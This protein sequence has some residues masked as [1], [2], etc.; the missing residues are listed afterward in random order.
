VEAALA[1]RPDL[2]LMDVGLKGDVDG[3]RASELINEKMH[4]PVVYLTGDS[5][6]KTLQRAKAASAYGY[7]LKPFHIRNL[8]VAIEVAVD[9]FEMERRLEDSQ[10]TYATILGSIADGVVAVDTQGCVRFMNG[11]AERLTGWAT[12][13]AQG[14]QWRTVLNILDNS[15]V[16]AEVDLVAQVLTSR[17]TFS[18]GPGSVVVG[19]DGTRAPVDGHLAC[20]VDSLGRVVGASIALHDVTNARKAEADLRASA[21]QLRAVIDTAVDG[22]L[23]LDAVGTIL[24]LNPACE[25]LFRYTSSEMTGLNIDAVM[26][27][28]L[29]GAHSNPWQFDLPESRRPMLVSARAVICRR[30]DRSTFP[31]EISVGE[32][33]YPGE[34]LFVCTVHDVSEQR[35]LEAALLDAVGREQR[36][37]ATDLHDGLGQ[38]LT[39]L[40]LLLSALTNTA[41]A[42]HNPHVQDLERA[43]EVVRHA[44]HSSQTIARG[45]SPIGPTDGG[46]IRALRDLV[47][48]LTDPSGPNV[49]ISVSEVAR[50]GL[51]AAASDHL[52]RIAQEALTNALK[53]AHAHSIRVTLDVQREHVR[54]EVCDDGWGVKNGGKNAPGLGLRTMQYRASILGARFVIAPFQPSG[55]RVICDCPQM[56]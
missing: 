43:C 22:V 44:L 27:S 33:S 31:A 11:V 15:D 32:A 3:I 51:T 23:M 38:E 45:L 34:S 42:A 12:R 39:G 16:Q 7:V 6:Q 20:V 25:R 52:Y 21:Q 47:A 14:E 49:D 5:D 13:D 54:L 41:R 9:R 36:R 19:R 4:V 17:T 55:T 24:M 29:F 35:E 46:L 2:I 48:R 8:I 10:L 26:G 1:L 18:L 56:A 50:L 53:H 30:R 37:F 40:S 28:P